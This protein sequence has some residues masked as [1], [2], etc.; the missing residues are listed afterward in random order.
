MPSSLLR[1]SYS[2]LQKVIPSIVAQAVMKR[3]GAITFG[4]ILVLG[5]ILTIGSSASAMDI[6]GWKYDPEKGQVEFEIEDGVKP[7]PFLMAQPARIVVDL[8][9]TQIG[10]APPETTYTSGPIQRITV[11]QLQP[12]LTRMTLY[13]FPSTVFAKGQVALDRLGDGNRGT[14]DIWALRPLV[15]NPRSMAGTST[16]GTSTLSQIQLKTETQTLVLPTAPTLP[17]APISQSIPIAVP[18]AKSDISNNSFI[19]SIASRFAN[20]EPATPPKLEELPPGMASVLLSQK[21][22]S[23]IA[24]PSIGL[25][26]LSAKAIPLP[27]LETVTPPPLEVDAVKSVTIEVPKPMIELPK[28]IEAPQPIEAPTPEITP[29]SP[30]Q[31]APPAPTFEQPNS[32]PISVSQTLNVPPPA[33]SLNV[34]VESIVPI[35]P[36]VPAPPIAVFT[37]NSQIFAQAGKGLVLPDSLPTVTPTVPQPTTVSVPPLSTISPVAQPRIQPTIVPNVVPNIAP[38]TVPNA[39]PN[40]NPMAFPLPDRVPQPEP[41]K[42]QPQPIVPQFTIQPTVQPTT[43]PSIFPAA[44]IAQPV[45]RNPIASSPSSVQPDVISFG[46]PLRPITP[47]PLSQSVPVSKTDPTTALVTMTAN[48]G[49]TGLPSGT[50]LTV[51]YTGISSLNVKDGSR[52]EMLVLQ[53]AIRDRNGMII[54]PEGTT[55]YG[56]FEGGTNQ[57]VAESIMIQGQLVSLIAESPNLGGARSPSERSLLQNSGIG[58]LAGVLIGG[59]SGGSAIGGAAAGAIA[60][61]VTAPKVATIQP[62]QM[63]ELKLTQ[64]WI[65][66]FGMTVSQGA[67]G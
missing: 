13:M 32:S 56:S 38:N 37:P 43:Q 9:N 14:S 40:V 5:G 54:A 15:T 7:R 46:Q 49:R 31:L 55:I 27:K 59:L 35:Q 1:N 19:P 66:P 4:S 23:T 36:I 18:S 52:K 6:A 41:L 12:L 64:D 67:G 34:P 42:I 58:V 20:I 61:Y 47:P 39:V 50:T 17:T 44:G 33:N 57:F 60:S 10:N 53:S 45:D 51:R 29:E 16:P 28:P 25:P 26:N 30:Q 3:F 48:D 8:L 11:V 21:P 24:P 62:G 65:I 63:L 22:G 2:S